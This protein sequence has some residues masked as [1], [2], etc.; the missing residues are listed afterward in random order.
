MLAE[1]VRCA[2]KAHSNCRRG[3]IQNQSRLR[4]LSC[5]PI[6]ARA[7]PESKSFHHQ[8]HSCLPPRFSTSLVARRDGQCSSL[9]LN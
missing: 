5:V 9:T 2:Y 3:H 6:E 7:S 1:F 8:H 4:R